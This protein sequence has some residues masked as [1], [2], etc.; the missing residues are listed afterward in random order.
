MKDQNIENVLTW[1]RPEAIYKR[2][3]IALLIGDVHQMALH[4][5]LGLDNYYFY[6]CYKKGIRPSLENLEKLANL[7][8]VSLQWLIHGRGDM[9]SDNEI[10][11]VESG[12]FIKRENGNILTSFTADSIREYLK[13]SVI[14]ARLPA[15]FSFADEDDHQAQH[16]RDVLL[17]ARELKQAVDVLTAQFVKIQTPKPEKY[18]AL[19]A[20][21]NRLLARFDLMIVTAS[22]YGN[23]HGE[24]HV[25]KHTMRD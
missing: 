14:D 21:F 11:K 9:F 25:L 10:I 13:P 24:L 3:K 7:C 16:E 1:Q 15:N 4:S 8:G 19:L 23:T 6:K 12:K 2:S 5:E 22:E 17:A 20:W 18:P